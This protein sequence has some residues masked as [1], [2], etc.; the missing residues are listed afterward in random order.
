M[1]NRKIP[2]AVS[3][4]LAG[5]ATAAGASEPVG[6]QPAAEAEI[7]AVLDA[8]M[9]EISANDLD[10]MKTRQTPDGMTYR[11]LKREDGGWEVKPR[12][13][14]AWVAPDMATKQKYRE[15]YW[16]PT[17]LIRGSMALVWTPYQFLVD[18]KTSHCGIDVFSFA[19]VKGVWKVSNQ[20]W[21][22]E[23]HACE[24][25]GFRG[26]EQLRPAL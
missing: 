2:L 23:P 16:S 7:L 12:S 10:A 13:N 24:E 6:H 11:H 17:V 15:R 22:V 18:G 4:L 8:Y 14:A 26:T 5:C 21:T 9:L 1:K 3:L 25:L 20:M 19:R